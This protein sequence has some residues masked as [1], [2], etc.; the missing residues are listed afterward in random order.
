MAKHHE[1]VAVIG[2]G[3]FGNALAVELDRRGT[4]VLAID[5]R[6]QVVQR[7]AGRLSRVIT[8]D[9][10][11]IDVLRELGVPD[12]RRVIVA[13]GTDQQSSIVTTALLSDL[14]IDDIWAKALDAQHASI[15]RRVGAHHVVLPEQQAGERVAHLVSGRFLDWIDISP[16]WALAKTT[17]PRE[18]VGVALG[19]SRIRQKR[20]VTVV[21]VRAQN[22][23]GFCHA[24]YDT[25]LSYGDEILIAGHPDDVEAFADAT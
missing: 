3:R 19:Q 16:D 6:P 14:Q 15:L 18:F 5:N 2:L 9:S 17:P 13:I 1:P 24:D 8:A 11:D 12:F 23:T 21:S 20:R 4:D 25:V 7:M 10:T 22:R